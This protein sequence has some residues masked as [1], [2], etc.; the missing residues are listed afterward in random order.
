MSSQ[1]VGNA[2]PRA[3]QM[4][5]VLTHDQIET[6]RRFASGPPRRF[7]SGE[8]VF[9]SGDRDVPVWLVLAG[10]IDVVRRDGL[11]DEAPITTHRAGQFTGEV[12][13]IDGRATIASARAG[14]DGAMLLPFDPPHLRALMIGSAEVGEIIM[15]ALILR[16]VGLIEQGGSGTILI[17][18]AHDAHLIRLQSFLTRD[19]YPNL[20][21]DP[22]TSGEGRSFV[23]KFSLQITDLPLVVCPNGKLLKRPTER[24]VAACLGIIPKIDSEKIYDVA[25]V[26]AGPAGLAAAV[27]GASE[28]LS[29]IVLDQRAMG[30]QAGASARIE[31]YLGFPTGISGQ[32]LAGRAFN[33]AIKFGA[34]V[35][36]PL[37]V[38]T[39]QRTGDRITL[40]LSDGATLAAN[41]VVIASGAAYQHPEIPGLAQLDGASVSYWAS[42]VEARLCRGKEIALVGGGNSAGQAIVFLTPQVK[43]LHVFVRRDLSETMSRYLIDRISALPNVEIHVGA[44]IA[45]LDVNGGVLSGATVRNR[46]D[47]GLSRFGISH[48]FL[49]VGATP[50]AGW[51]RDTLATDEKGF[52]LTGGEE[53]LPLETSVPGVFAIGDVRAGSTK[54]V[55]AAV[56][57]GAAVVAQIHGY[58]G[59]LRDR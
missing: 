5:P 54:R 53:A 52:I 30:G 23:E 45:E 36:I 32:A 24:E 43:R 3:H 21:I 11:D 2:A 20:V 44:E 58:L 27:Y 57:D 33:Q 13:Q 14:S 55:A 22:V 38:E 1:T 19:G 18:S 31:N 59:A 26:G 8:P 56:G 41:T 47:H 37:R 46:S 40:G 9:T 34:E 16:R 39:L 28:G 17:G 42:A 10:S 25:I 35:A 15:R 48:L 50:H 49:F 7:T 29:V 4:F 6:M 12:S 51:L